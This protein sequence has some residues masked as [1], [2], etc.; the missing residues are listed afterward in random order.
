ME[1]LLDLAFGHKEEKGITT[2]DE[3]FTRMNDKNVLTS[4]N[5][6]AAMTAEFLLFPLFHSGQR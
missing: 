4:T 2:F 5:P 6:S 1:L 3:Y